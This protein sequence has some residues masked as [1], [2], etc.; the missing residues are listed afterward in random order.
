MKLPELVIGDLVAKIPIIQGGMGVG[1]SLSNLAA[2]VARQGGIGILSGVQMGFREL[3]FASHPLAAN[4]RA[5]QQEIR[6]ARELAPQG[7]LGINIMTVATQYKELV[8]T[9]VRE[10]VDLIIAGSGLPKDLP[11][12]VLGTKTKILPVVSSGK[13]AK[14]MAK[15]WTRNYDYLPDGFIVEGPKA[16]GH[17]GF[18][19]ETILE[20]KTTL[21]SLLKE[22]LDAIRPFEEEYQR[23]IPVIVAGGITNGREMANYIKEGA[24][25]VQIATVLVATEECDAHPRFKEAYV[26]ATPEDAVIVQSPVGLPGRAIRNAFLDRLEKGRIPPK[27][28]TNCIVP[29]QPK[30]TLYCISDALIA[31]VQGDV[32][33]GLIFCGSE[34]GSI[35]EITTV[36]QV[37]NRFVQE[38]E[39]VE[40]SS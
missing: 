32:E 18:T 15:L 1:V 2:A 29:C 20:G 23:K 34:V 37:L 5:I 33:N 19:K 25:G 13:A 12:Y 14:I 8:E 24:S 10:K 27:S 35:K 21:S 39:E 30:D 36:E 38:A 7:I 4:I 26:N 6:K 11:Q 40:F 17:L 28:C 16:G 22:V 9:A 3:D 31:A